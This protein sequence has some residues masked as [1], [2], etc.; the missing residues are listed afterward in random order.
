[1]LVV[2]TETVWPAKPKIFEKVCQSLYWSM[3]NIIYCMLMNIPVGFLFIVGRGS[4]TPR[5]SPWPVRNLATQ[6]EVSSGGAS[7]ASSVTL[8]CSPSLAL[9]PETSP[10]TPI[11][12]KIVFHK[13]GPWCQKDW[14][15]LL[16]DT[17][18]AGVVSLRTYKNT[19]ISC[20][21]WVE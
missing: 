7:E 2:I 14:G 1:M 16:Q 13:T 12:G 4:T 11:H 19:D 17:H 18:T 3:R 8:H 9:L 10:P 5:T 6:Q 20:L 15:P 21:Y